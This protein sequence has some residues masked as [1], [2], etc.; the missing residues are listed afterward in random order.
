MSGHCVGMEVDGVRDEIRELL[1]YGLHGNT[2]ADMEVRCSSVDR[3]F[4]LSQLGAG[5][6]LEVR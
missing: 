3:G 6:V 5:Q 4:D 2:V 1:E